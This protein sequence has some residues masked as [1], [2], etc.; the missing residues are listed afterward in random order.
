[1]LRSIGAIVAGFLVIGA[2]SAGS[3]AVMRG[4]FP[5][6][7][8]GANDLSP[9]VIRS[10]LVALFAIFGC[11]LTAL[12]APNHPM[13]HAL[14]LGALG[15]AFNIAT[16][17]PMWGT[18]PSWFIIVNLLL[19]MPYAW[20]GGWLRERQLGSASGALSPAAVP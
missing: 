17:L 18:V 14:I 15:L 5:A 1:M 10:A 2:L 7:G 19:V 16:S 20:I 4:M 11:Y 12:L 8:E 3:D 9:L 6:T 13:R